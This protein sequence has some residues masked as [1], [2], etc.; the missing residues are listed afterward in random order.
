MAGKTYR[1]RI[2]PNPTFQ[3]VRGLTNR[4]FDPDNVVSDRGA[5]EDQL[6]AV[7]NR[8]MELSDWIDQN[9]CHNNQ[10]AVVQVL[11]DR[12][13]ALETR[14]GN[15]YAVNGGASSADDDNEI[16][17]SFAWNGPAPFTDGG[18]A[19]GFSADPERTIASY[20]FLVYDR[21]GDVY[22]KSR[23]ASGGAF[24]WS[25]DNSG[26]VTAST[27]GTVGNSAKG[28]VAVDSQGCE[29]MVPVT[30]PHAVGI[31]PVAQP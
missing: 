10:D 13:D 1:A 22:I 15:C 3:T 29:G 26:N 14:L 17:V 4:T 24:V 23:V 31:D 30:L 7:Y 21:G 18:K 5:T 6:L 9:M 8:H 20:W 11:I 25:I 19:T 2:V 16:T 28:I 27:N 12:L